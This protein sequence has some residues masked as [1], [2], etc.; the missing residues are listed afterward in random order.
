MSRLLMTP[1]L[2]VGCQI[3]NIPAVRN[4][5][6]LRIVAACLAV[7]LA[8]P[9]PGVMAAPAGTIEGAVTLADRPLSGAT[10][11]FVNLTYGSIH[12]A[13]S[14]SKGHFAA[15]VPAGQYAV[16]TPGC[17]S[18]KSTAR[19]AATARGLK[20]FLTAGSLR[21]CQPARNGGIIRIPGILAPAD[22]ARPGSHNRP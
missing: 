13:V 20:W 6:R 16:T 19:Q 10:L 17:G 3:A 21:S 8:L 11:A 2:R 15:Q 4:H 5:F 9:Q 22:G 18:A 1:R 7:L 14:D 12:R